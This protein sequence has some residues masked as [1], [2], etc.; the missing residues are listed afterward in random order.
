MRVGSIGYAT[1][2]GLGIL[3]KAFYDHGIVTDVLPVHHPKNENQSWY[4]DCWYRPD[5]INEVF[6]F[7]RQMD[8]MLFF[9]T[10]FYIQAIPFCKE[11][12][13]KSVLMPM[14]ECTPD[15][16]RIGEPEVNPAEWTEKGL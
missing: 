13:I 6:A 3:L 9:E 12:G 8:I 7:I 15:L 11:H 1:H 10:S 2:Q 4:G 5:S 16:N 14:Y